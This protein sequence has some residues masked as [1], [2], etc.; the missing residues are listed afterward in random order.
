M[1]ERIYIIGGLGSGK[2]YLAKKL[3]GSKHVV[4][5]DL[6]KIVFLNSSFKERDSKERDALFASRCSEAQWVIEGT[7][8]EDW[9]RLG[10]EEADVI[11]YLNIHP[12]VRFFRFIKRIWGQGILQQQNLFGR[13]LLVLGFRYK[14]YDRTEACYKKILKKHWEKV[15]ELKSEKEVSE[16]L[17]ANQT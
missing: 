12:L 6:D 10:L 14:E 7:Y 9:I 3:S 4:H 5:Y 13:I 15:V 1:K 17:Q 11:I 8:T 2:S 16:Y